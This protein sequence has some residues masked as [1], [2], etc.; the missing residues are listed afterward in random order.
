HHAG[1]L[2]GGHGAGAG[3]SQQIDQDV[4]CGQEEKIVVGGAQKFLALTAR[5]PANRLNALDAERFNDGAHGHK[6][7]FIVLRNAR[8]VQAVKELPEMPKLPKNPNWSSRQEQRSLQFGFFGTFGN[9]GNS[10]TVTR[11]YI[12][13]NRSI[14][15]GFMFKSLAWP[16]IAA[17]SSRLKGL[18][19]WVNPRRSRTWRGICASA[20]LT[21]LP[22]LSR[23]APSSD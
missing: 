1:P 20:G 15:L 6:A 14:R 8:V 23:A 9:I 5:G 7:P 4:F 2:L 10:F 13:R 12:L 3:I 19:A 17:S 21:P 18:T 16:D 11:W 22:L